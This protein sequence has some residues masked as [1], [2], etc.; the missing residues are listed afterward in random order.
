MSIQHVN[1]HKPRR[2]KVNTC[3]GSDDGADAVETNIFA[4]SSEGG[5]VIYHMSHNGRSFSKKA[6][7]ELKTYALSFI[8]DK[9]SSTTRSASRLH[10]ENEML[11]DRVNPSDLNLRVNPYGSSSSLDSATFVEIGNLNSEQASALR[12]AKRLNAETCRKERIFFDDNDAD[13]ADGRRSEVGRS[14]SEAVDRS[15]QQPPSTVEEVVGSI[16]EELIDAAMAPPSS[17]VQ[18]FGSVCSSVTSEERFHSRRLS[19][20]SRDSSHNDVDDMATIIG[21]GHVSEIDSQSDTTVEGVA[22]KQS[23]S[24]SSAQTLTEELPNVHPLH[25]HI[26][27][28]TQKYDAR[29]TLY[30]LSCLRALL[31]TNP[32]LIACALT[33]SNIG[34]AAAPH[35]E[36][37]QMLL[38][39]HRRSVLGKSFH[40]RLPPDAAVGVR[41]SMF[42]EVLITVCLYFV[43]SY[44]PNLMMSK[45]GEVELNANKEIQTLACE[46]CPLVVEYYIFV[47]CMP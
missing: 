44:Y 15:P 16:L 35:V 40:G 28:Y 21:N 9:G 11:F 13:E 42:V 23:T 37:L 47:H 25:T 6:T 4:I 2:I 14:G 20:Q 8:S 41:S 45:L 36:Q 12:N 43:R 29:R 31:A 46:V 39:R 33:T 10:L 32:R 1:I 19:S 7:E 5:N 26:L 38:I 22:V 3:E 34:S 17:C 24:F 27:L 18:M 30:A